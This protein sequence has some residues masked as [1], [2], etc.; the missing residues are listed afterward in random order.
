MTLEQAYSQAG[1]TSPCPASDAS[2]LIADNPNV[3]AY[4]DILCKRHEDLS[5]ATI[6]EQIMQPQEIKARL[7]ELA[8]ANLVDFLDPSGRPKL[9]KDVPHHAAAKKYYRK[10]RVDRFGNPIETSE[11]ALVDQIEALRELAKIHGMY[12]PEKHLIAKKVIVEM[13]DKRRGEVE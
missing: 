7:S 4:Y 2:H 13:I 3:K 6:A 1:Y 5:L 12:A 11:I 9:S 10:S 8:R